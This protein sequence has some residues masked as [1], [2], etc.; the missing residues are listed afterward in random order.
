MDNV[1][2]R[3]NSNVDVRLLKNMRFQTYDVQIYLD[4]KNV[5]NLKILNY[6]GFVDSYDYQAYLASLCFPWE[7]GDQKGNDRLGD[8]RPNGVA[9]DPLEP[10]PN[11]DPAVTA[12]NNVRKA[13]KSYID[14]PN[15]VSVTFLNPRDF[16][17]GIRF[18]F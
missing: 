4:V 5:F 8:Y 1:Q 9:F 17:F 2:W 7:S 14:M 6:A 18:S 3:D 12:R 11:N 15:D 13:K 16:S 10:N